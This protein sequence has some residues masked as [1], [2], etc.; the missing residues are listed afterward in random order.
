MEDESRS[1]LEEAERRS[2]LAAEQARRHLALLA[3]GGRAL[4]G[5][6]DD[7]VAALR[8][9]VD[10]VVPTFAD[11]C[12][13]DLII[14]G[15]LERVAARHADPAADA[16]LAALAAE[17]PGW[18]GPVRRVMATGRSELVKDVDAPP[19]DPVDTDHRRALRAVG[20]RSCL[21]VAVRVQGLSV[22]AISCATG[23]ERRGF[24]PSDMAAVEELAARAAA[25][26]ERVALLREARR[27]AAEAAERARQLRQL[28]GAAIALQ[29]QH[30]SRDVASVL[31]HQATQALGARHAVVSVRDDHGP[32]RAVAGDDEGFPTGELLQLLERAEAGEL[33]GIEPW[34]DPVT[35]A[36]G[37]VA[38][39]ITDRAGRAVGALLV[40]DRYSGGF[41]D[42]DA[43]VLVALVHITSVALDNARLYETVMAGEAHLRALVEGAP[44]A[45][46]E[47]DLDGAVRHANAAAVALLG[48]AD[49]PAPTGGGAIALDPGTARLLGRLAADTLA[50]EPVHDLELVTRRADGTE[51]PLSLAAAPL[52]NASGHVDGVLVL[53]TDL[54]AR[55]DLE[56]Q[57]VRAQRM[58]AVGQVAG[59]VAH[60]F[61]NLLTVILGHATLLDA[62]LPEADQRRD[63][64]TAIAT[65]A[66]RAAGV[67]SQL[68][69]ISRG[70]RVASELFDPRE[71]LGHLSDMVRR[72]LP[73][74]VELVADVAPGG[75]LVRM[76][77]A[78]F[79]QVVLNLTVNARDAMPD[80]GTLTLRLHDDEGAVVLATVDTG[81]G[82]EEEVA[83]RCF[84]PFFSTKGGNRGTGLGLATVHSIVTAAGGHVAVD[85]AP[86]AG[87]TFTVRLPAVPG[88]VEAAGPGE[89]PE[90][91]AAT[92]GGERILLVEDEAGLRRL[93]AEVLR[94]AGYDV[95]A[96]PD[97]QAAVEHLAG[98]TAPP[99]LLVTDV[100]MP[101][102]GGVE[103]ADRFAADHPGVPV[104]FLTGYV[105]HA[106]RE[107]LADADVLIKPFVVTEL[108]R[109]V[110]DALDRVAPGGTGPR[111]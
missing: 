84:E 22:G 49:V 6:A 70:D 58:E 105:D 71:R 18:A 62:T 36:V 68:L 29:P 21:T 63:D 9:L 79:D 2:R 32:F 90:G 51:V 13:V 8:S 96:L 45:I 64:V 73:A 85:T 74:S 98:E 37:G 38:V 94:S 15:V 54:S 20:A 80:G 88:R 39:S 104:L 11:W 61:N 23:P 60:D 25:A 33:D 101:R 92:A 57:L 43:A 10:V 19:A 41:S 72:L 67:T 24:R 40:A 77:P 108:V 5:P 110:R 56:E 34:R 75:G 26:V 65:A 31:A 99:D 103:L 81:T 48:G 12:A 3:E 89:A 14:D 55:R 107:G 16:T 52:R 78:Q 50:D 69:T 87:T 30:R 83:R 106:S 102:M 53:A 47:L 66:E 1:R 7:E 109:R 86:G 82:M 59:G 46:L 95:T 91:A 42:D 28:V 35:G 93:E 76:S 17:L 4:M 97:G 27:S 111:R 44:L 100:V